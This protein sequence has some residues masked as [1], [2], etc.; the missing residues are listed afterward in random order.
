[1]GLIEEAQFVWLYWFLAVQ[2]LARSPQIV[3]TS[4]SMLVAGMA[5]TYGRPATVQSAGAPL[6]TS[7][8]LKKQK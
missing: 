4:L 6:A 1:L 2:V 7:P 8:C 3:V 5:L